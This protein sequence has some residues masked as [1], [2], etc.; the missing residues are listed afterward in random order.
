MTEQYYIRRLLFG[1][2]FLFPF[3]LPGQSS[4][5][6]GLSLIEA[7]GQL[8]KADAVVEDEDGWKHYYQE[9][10]QKLLLS[11]QSYGQDIGS[12]DQQLSISC[13]LLRNY[14]KGANDLSGADYVDNS[15]WLT[16]NRYWRISRPNP[17]GKTVRLR[18]YFTENDIQDIRN[19]LEKMGRTFSHLHD[20]Q[21]YIL[22]GG[23]VHPFSTQ[24]KASRAQFSL[25]E[26]GPAP[27]IGKIGETYYV[28]YLLDNLA[29]SGSGGRMIPLEGETYSVKGRITNQFGNPIEDI[30]IESAIPGASIRTDDDGAF[31]LANLEAGESYQIKPYS[32]NRPNENVTVLDLLGMSAVLSG[33]HQIESPYTRMG[34]DL[35]GS[36]QLDEQDLELLQAI[37]LGDTTAF[38]Q[39]SA[40]HF[41]PVSESTATGSKRKLEDLPEGL[42]I[43]NLV[44]NITEQDFIGIKIGDLWEEMRFPDKGL[45]IPEPGFILENVAVCGN[46]QK[47]RVPLKVERMK[48]IRAFQFTIEWDPEI[49]KF[50]EVNG[51]NL[52][53]LSE[54]NIG[55]FQAAQGKLSIAWFAPDPVPAFKKKDGTTICFLEFQVISSDQP[56]TKIDFTESL[57]AIQVLSDE[58]NTQNVFF[59]TGKVQFKGGDG[60]RFDQIDVQAAKCNGGG[61]AIR[62]EVSGGNP[63]YHFRWDHGSSSQNAENLTAGHYRLTVYDKS[64][65]PLISPL[66]EVPTTDP[67]KLEHI[68]VGHVLCEDQQ[69]GSVSFKT[70]GGKPPYTYLWDDGSNNHWHTSLA[71]G[72]HSVTVTDRA[73]CQYEHSF[74][75][76]RGRQSYL[77]YSLSPSDHPRRPN[78]TIRISS[79]E[80]ATPPLSYQWSNG[81]K[82]SNAQKLSPGI[83]GLTLT[84]GN[85]CTNE[86]AFTI[87]DQL[88]PEAEVKL[89]EQPLKA[90]AYFTLTIPVQ[91]DKEASVLITDLFGGRVA[92]KRILLYRGE[93]QYH[94]RA[95]KRAGVYSIALYEKGGERW[96]GTLEVKE[97]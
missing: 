36:G 17:I 45:A 43:D 73:G 2:S 92:E 9:K 15:I 95:P 76:E 74:M 93:N 57:S 90:G 75:I 42:T 69:Q 58:F 10:E 79:I 81:A 11:I 46:R 67:P 68:R 64:D 38:Q 62:V 78:G 66:I 91:T 25:F 5:P 35:D 13:G 60:K 18:F 22:D 21:F 53:Y 4:L 84:D 56:Q 12:I 23:S 50:A 82:G 31:A 89:G 47:I 6:G 63:P 72:A 1:I 32:L 19:S 94:L 44:N 30:Y 27:R 49:L 39:Q 14:G 87:S 29:C 40:W 80:Q 8:L 24:S 20:L 52:P 61:G 28:E 97:K 70:T 7:P 85:G 83:H 16:M 65:C 86:Y 51:F 3:I 96:S 54:K 88:D 41:T 26:S 33:E 37:V 55:A 59:T 71:P 34:S 48:N 77:N